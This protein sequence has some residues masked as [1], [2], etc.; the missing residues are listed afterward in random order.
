LAYSV[1][2]LGQA[3]RWTKILS[4]STYQNRRQPTIAKWLKI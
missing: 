4:G 1:E 2:K 3:G